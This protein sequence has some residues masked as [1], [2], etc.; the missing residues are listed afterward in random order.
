M[1][2]E[3]SFGSRIAAIWQA[4]VEHMKLLSK[5]DDEGSP[6]DGEGNDQ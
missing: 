1:T 4:L 6:S 2:N 5:A 3:S